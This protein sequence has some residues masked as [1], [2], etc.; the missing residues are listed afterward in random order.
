MHE[1]SH[2]L[3]AGV[4]FVRTGEIEFLPKM[5]GD[6]VKLGSVAIE[7][8]DPVRRA[9]IGFASVFVGLSTILG[10]I[11]F[12]ADNSSIVR[13]IEPDIVVVG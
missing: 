9:I 8:T 1:L 4:L 2:L 13:T 6:Q 10:I 12:V 5:E 11:Y 7:K 3:T